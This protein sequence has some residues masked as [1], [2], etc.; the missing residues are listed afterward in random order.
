MDLPLTGEQIAYL[1]LGSP[2]YTSVP[3]YFR[4][5]RGMLDLA[6]LRRALTFVMQRHDA[7]RIRL[8]RDESVPG[9]YWQR[10]EPAPPAWDLVVRDQMP[11]D[12]VRGYVVAFARKPIDLEREPAVDVR[13]AAITNG[14]HLVLLNVHHL[15]TDAWGAFHIARDLWAAYGAYLMGAEPGI[16]SAPSFAEHVRARAASGEHLSRQQV[17]YW[18]DAWAKNRGPDLPLLDAADSHAVVP[19]LTR[20]IPQL[21]LDE[22]GTSRLHACAKKARVTFPILPLGAYAFALWAEYGSSDFIISVLHLGRDSDDEMRTVG[23]F[24][25]H[26]PVHVNISGET[27]LADNLQGV[28]RSWTKAIRHAAPP[29]S[30]PRM[31][32]ELSALGVPLPDGKAEALFNMVFLPRG[33]AA[34]GSGVVTDID[35]TPDRWAWLN[36]QRL[37]M[38]VSPHGARLR[39]NPR[40]SI[41]YLAPEAMT[42]LMT[43]L[44]RILDM[45]SA[46]NLTITAAELA[47][48]SS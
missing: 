23:M 48:R 32:S 43:R 8:V 33:L 16:Q 42:T 28:M 34:V 40:Y 5:R 24:E 29:F 1:G 10:F 45:Y 27:S 2:N 11:E 6:V 26:V 9:G 12:D 18:T 22:E 25:R 47:A 19:P 15:A 35:V 14:D 21:V 37:R 46:D 7:L 4:I 13:V 36:E 31:K 3:L 44:S 41:K 38:I 39:I 17:E 20:G 30:I